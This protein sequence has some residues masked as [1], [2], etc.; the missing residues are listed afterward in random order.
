MHSAIVNG[1]QLLCD[2]HTVPEEHRESAAL[3][4][5]FTHYHPFLLFFCVFVTLPVLFIFWGASIV[6]VKNLT[7]AADYFVNP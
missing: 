4:F 3:Y 2:T 1:Y 5:S 6:C 7:R